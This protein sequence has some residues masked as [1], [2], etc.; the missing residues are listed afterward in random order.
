MTR[1]TTNPLHVLAVGA[2]AL[3]ACTGAPAAPP[4]PTGVPAAAVWSGG[5]DGGQ[6]FHIP[7]CNGTCSVGT[8]CT[9]AFAVVN[10]DADGSLADNGFGV[11]ALAEQESDDQPLL[12]LAAYG[13]T[14]SRVI[15]NC[16]GM[17]ATRQYAAPAVARIREETI[18]LR[19]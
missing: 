13:S 9:T 5:R 19:L 16:R 1:I 12:H 4:R 15:T 17:V 11:V 8:D 10:V 3:G 14:V 18:T 7:Y 6:W 2:S